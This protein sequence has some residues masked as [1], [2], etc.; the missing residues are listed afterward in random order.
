MKTF[1]DW[2]ELNESL[3][4]KKEFKGLF[5][6]NEKDGLINYVRNIIESENQKIKDIM[7]S[8]SIPL[9]DS[10]GFRIY[11]YTDCPLVIKNDKLFIIFQI[12][13]DYSEQKTDYAFLKSDVLKEEKDFLSKIPYK[14]TI[15]NEVVK[16]NHGA[17]Y[18][19]VQKELVLEVE[20]I[21]ANIVT[22]YNYNNRGTKLKRFGV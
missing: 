13:I 4:L 18:I 19:R 21:F 17:A 8:L 16:S 22:L 20:S 5:D 11:S 2:K 6:R 14:F 15:Q 7:D 1:I 10:K 9:K 3:E 12:E